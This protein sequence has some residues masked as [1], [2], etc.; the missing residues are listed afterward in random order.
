MVN[1]T[2]S[3]LIRFYSPFTRSK[4][5]QD[6]PNKIIYYTCI[7]KT[8]TQVSRDKNIYKLKDTSSK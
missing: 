7:Y 1:R 5:F 4:V 3:S 6:P 2:F 8:I